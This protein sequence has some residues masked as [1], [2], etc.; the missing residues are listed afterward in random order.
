MTAT[1]T[2]KPTVKKSQPKPRV[3]Q[4]QPQPR[5]I[6]GP[7]LLIQ[8]P[9]AYEILSLIRDSINVAL[10]DMT[11]MPQA[12]MGM[13]GFPFLPA[14]L[15]G[16]PSRHDALIDNWHKTYPEQQDRMQYPPRPKQYKPA[17]ATSAPEQKTWR[18]RVVEWITDYIGPREAGRSD[19]DYRQ[20]YKG[21]YRQLMLRYGF[22]VEQRARNFANKYKKAGQPV[23]EGNEPMDFVERLGMTEELFKIVCE[24]YPLHEVDP[25]F[26]SE[27]VLAGL[28]GP[29][30]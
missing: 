9:S 8:A 17:P 22:D 29:Q 14:S 21:A 3:R 30:G 13:G 24:I 20:A 18:A 27:P 4:S 23:P 16:F 19:E 12:P 7:A 26:R 28:Q 2:K 11:M 6:T 25:A 1:K 10:N 15:P 5:Q